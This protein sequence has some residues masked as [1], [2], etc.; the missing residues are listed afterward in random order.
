MFSYQPLP[1]SGLWL[2]VP[3]IYT[4]ERGSFAEILRM[5]EFAQTTGALPFVQ[6]N[7][8]ISTRGVLRGM[9]FQCGAMA[10]SKL[11]RCV[12]GEILD[13][14]VDIR[15]HSPTFGQ[16]HTVKLSSQEKNLF[17]IPRGFAHGFLTLSEQAIV[18]YKVDN[19]YHRES[20]GS[21]SA[22]DPLLTAAW[23]VGGIAQEN[24]ILS[25]KDREAPSWNR[26]VEQLLHR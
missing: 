20:E 24:I 1:L 13:I 2:I 8:S 21:F 6:E 17:Y 22:L 25:Y 4:D 3:Q 18:N 5:D 23:Q 9:H 7:E 11:V 19:L 10:Q 26:W 12:S 16:H 15:P 14:A